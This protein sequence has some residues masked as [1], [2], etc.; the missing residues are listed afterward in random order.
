MTL[1]ELSAEYRQSAQLLRT[2]LKELRQV[3]K[4]A[5]TADERWHIKRRIYELTPILTQTN[6]VAELLEKYYDGGYYRDA[7]YSCN[8]L[9]EGI[10]RTIRKTN[11]HHPG[12][13]DGGPEGYSCALL[14]A[15][16]ITKRVRQDKRRQ[17]VNR[18]PNPEKGY[19]QDS[20]LHQ[21][22][23]NSKPDQ[24]ALESLFP[25]LEKK[26]DIEK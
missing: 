7:N 10:P 26:G 14:D 20:A 2:R 6:K 16:H 22:L 19:D 13:A 4:V 25:N 21:I 8:A 18:E 9:R 11:A 3:L 24:K 17:Q 23:V 12:G 5:E 15:G 1:K